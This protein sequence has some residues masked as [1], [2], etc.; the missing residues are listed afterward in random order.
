MSEHTPRTRF[1]RAP[2]AQRK[3]L[4]GFCWWALLNCDCGDVE[5]WTVMGVRCFGELAADMRV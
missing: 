5:R 4:A 3:G 1:A 2:F